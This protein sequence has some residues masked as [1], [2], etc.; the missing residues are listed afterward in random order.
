MRHFSFFAAYWEHPPTRLRFRVRHLISPFTHEQPSP[1]SLYLLFQIATA[2]PHR[3]TFIWA[4][5]PAMSLI[6]RLTD[7]DASQATSSNYQAAAQHGAFRFPD[8]IDGTR[9]DSRPH[10]MEQV[11]EEEDFELKRPPYLHVGSH[12]AGRE[13]KLTALGNVCWRYWG[14]HRR[15]PYALARYSQNA[16]TRRSS[17]PT[18]VHIVVEFLRQNLSARR[19]SAWTIWRLHRCHAGLVPW[20]LHVL[21]SL[22]IYETANA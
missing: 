2:L 16:T 9:Q 11:T 1:F 13:S 15:H 20:D 6:N 4:L 3:L 17:F 10:K 21:R 22:R 7:P 5:G 8:P 12:F 19:H 18:E 14:N